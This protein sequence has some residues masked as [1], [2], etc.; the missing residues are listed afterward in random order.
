MNMNSWI[1]R[2]EPLY[3]I[4]TYSKKKYYIKEKNIEVLDELIETKKFVRFWKARVNVSS[5]DTIEPA[6]AEDNF[7]QAEIQNYS[8]QD[9]SIIK[10]EVKLWKWRTHKDLTPYVLKQIIETYIEKN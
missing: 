6:K 2:Y 7:Y 8:Y 1:V 4:L 3:E 10:K 5:I 9:Q